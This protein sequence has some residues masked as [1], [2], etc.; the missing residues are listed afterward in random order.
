MKLKNMVASFLPWRCFHCGEVFFN[1]DTARK[2]FGNNPSAKPLCVLKK[3]LCHSC[4]C[5]PT[6]CV[7]R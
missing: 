1:R 2:H 3:C 5:N 7:G 6:E 4:S